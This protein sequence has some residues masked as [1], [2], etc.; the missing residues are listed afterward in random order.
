MEESNTTTTKIT[1][2]NSMK[3]NKETKKAYQMIEDG[4]VFWIQ[5]R[6]LRENGTLTAAGEKSRSQA[7]PEVQGIKLASNKVDIPESIIDL[8]NYEPSMILYSEKAV[9]SGK[10]IVIEFG[11][12]GGNM[13]T[14][15]LKTDINEAIGKPAFV[16]IDCT[17]RS[18]KAGWLA[19]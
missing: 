19:E 8:F 11:S 5:R 17:G 12:M 2:S 18:G 6:W 14:R 9:K 1:G 3:I 16:R 7:R 13:Q 4:R 10:W 15:G